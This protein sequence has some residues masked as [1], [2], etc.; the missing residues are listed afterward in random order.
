MTI[1]LLLHHFLPYRETKYIHASTADL[2]HTVLGNLDWC[3]FEHCKNEAR[4]TG[5]LLRGG[6]NAYCFD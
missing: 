5:C 1:S 6:C 3:K 4:E 2:L